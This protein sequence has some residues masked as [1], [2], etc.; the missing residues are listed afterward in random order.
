M[1]K[2]WEQFDAERQ[3]TWTH[4]QGQDYYKVVDAI[5][6]RDLN[7]VRAICERDGTAIHISDGLGRRPLH[8]AAWQGELDI[9]KYLLSQ[10]ADANAL[11]FAGPHESGLTA[12]SIAEKEGHEEVAAVLRAAMGA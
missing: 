11:E 2:T 9:A 8:V 7:G 5:R 3:V 12:L 1:S 10:G 4:E 6:A